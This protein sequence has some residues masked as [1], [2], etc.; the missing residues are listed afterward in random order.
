MVCSVITLTLTLTLTLTSLLG[1]T[2]KGVTDIHSTK[3]PNTRTTVANVVA[4]IHT[5]TTTTTTTTTTTIPVVGKTR[6]SQTQIISPD[7]KTTTQLSSP[8]TIPDLHSLSIHSN[9]NSNCSNDSS[10]NN[11][12]NT[13]KLNMPTPYVPPTTITANNS[14]NS[15]GIKL[16]TIT[17]K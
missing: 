7:N 2:P 1:T 6:R 15:I 5:P 13:F 10:N 11:D 14:Q 9:N 4:H 12:H 17:G 16:K 3:S 8:L